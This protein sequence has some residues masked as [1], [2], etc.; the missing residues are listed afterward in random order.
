MEIGIKI[1]A[2]KIEERENVRENYLHI[3]YFWKYTTME[4]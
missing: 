3:I 2:Q 4:S 1:I